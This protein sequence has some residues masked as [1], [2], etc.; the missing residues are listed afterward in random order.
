MPKAER[1]KLTLLFFIGISVFGLFT[2]L[3]FALYAPQ[4]QEDSPWRKPLIGSVFALICAS[5]TI[6]AFFP[7]RCSET[8]DL[9]EKNGYTTVQPKRSLSSS[10][11]GHHPKCGRFSAHAITVRS[12]V[13]CA[14]CTGLAA[15]AIIALSG[16]IL[17]FFLAYS[18]EQ[19]GIVAV[20]AGQMA[21]VLGFLQMRFKDG[22]RLMLNALFVFGAFLVLI[23]VDMIAESMLFDLYVIGLIVF[24]IWTRILLSQWDHFRICH[25]CDKDCDF[26]Q[27]RD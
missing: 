21:V 10:L 13:L 22:I 17:Y 4:A 12:I 14:A 24:W 27:K 19:M 7:H 2:S 6:A 25:S 3:M 23:G 8:F 20:V 11:K 5:G 26:K 16:S 9:P 1:S 15:G 18:F